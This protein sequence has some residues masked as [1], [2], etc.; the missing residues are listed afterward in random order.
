MYDPSSMVILI[1][2]LRSAVRQRACLASAPFAYFVW[3]AP[4]IFAPKLFCKA[5]PWQSA[6]QA[7]V[8]TPVS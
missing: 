6:H 3:D 1:L 4:L 8:Y 7:G 2:L 5:C